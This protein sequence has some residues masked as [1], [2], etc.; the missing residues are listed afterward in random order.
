MTGGNIV[1]FSRQANRRV[2]LTIGIDYGDNIDLAKATLMDEMS[3]HPLVLSEPAPFVGVVGLGDN[4]VNI[5]TR[6]WCKSA[7]Y[8]TVYFE[9]T[10][11]IKKRFDAEG[12][13]FPF[14]QRDVHM[15]K[16]D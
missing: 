10:E 15:H 9:L 5:A 14:P 16:V 6:P 13:S 8:W 11:S 12:L 3:K 2:D 1:N 7:D 4:S